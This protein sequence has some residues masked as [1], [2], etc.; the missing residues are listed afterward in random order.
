M[1]P[2]RFSGLIPNLVQF[3]A[4]QTQKVDFLHRNFFKSA[5]ADAKS[6]YDKVRYYAIQ[7]TASQFLDKPRNASAS[8]LDLS[9]SGPSSE[10]RGRHGVHQLSPLVAPSSTC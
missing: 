10:M 2:T 8:V 6:G 5:H 9:F 1:L 3:K 4:T 7:I